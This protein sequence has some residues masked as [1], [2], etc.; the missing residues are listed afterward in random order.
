MDKEH[1]DIELPLKLTQVAKERGYFFAGIFVAS[2]QPD[3]RVEDKQCRLDPCY[4]LTEL[5]LVLGQIEQNPGGGDDVDGKM[6][7]AGVG[8]GADARKTLPDHI[9][10]VLCGKKKHRAGAKDLETAQTGCA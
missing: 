6:I 2:M 9:E 3:E 7:E 10:C 5:L 4:G 1:C 8:C